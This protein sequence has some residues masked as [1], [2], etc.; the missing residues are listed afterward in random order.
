MPWVDGEVER[1]G[2]DARLASQRPSWDFDSGVPRSW[3]SSRPFLGI[4]VAGSQREGGSP[5]QF[6]SKGSR[7]TSKTEARGEP[8]WVT[9]PQ[10]LAA[11]NSW[12]KAVLLNPSITGHLRL[13]PVLSH[14]PSCVAGPGTGTLA[15]VPGDSSMYRYF[16]LAALWAKVG[17][18]GEEQA[19]SRV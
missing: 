19:P 4:H 15:S 1:V 13:P 14:P 2:S 7:L 11:G 18:W 3:E 9:P 5:S 8:L 12:S 10:E 17:T 6:R 16:R